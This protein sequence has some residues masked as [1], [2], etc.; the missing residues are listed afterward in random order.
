M[1]PHSRKKGNHTNQVTYYLGGT[2][3]TNDDLGKMDQIN[4]DLLQN[5]RGIWGYASP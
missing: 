3:Q 1:F 2:D 5:V 4:D